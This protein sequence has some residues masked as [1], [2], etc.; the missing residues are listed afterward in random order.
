VKRPSGVLNE[1]WKIKGE[2]RYQKDRVGDEGIECARE[3]GR[4]GTKRRRI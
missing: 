2:R 1:D 3:K 4:V